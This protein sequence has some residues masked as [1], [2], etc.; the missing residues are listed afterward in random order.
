MSIEV[1]KP[2]LF[3]TIQDLGRVGFQ[4]LGVPVSGVMDELSH[5][6]ANLL[7]GNDEHEATLEITLLGP[8]L[9][10]GRGAWIVLA[11]AD[12]GAVSTAAGP[13]AP[14]AVPVPLETPTWIA[15]GAT[16]Q[17][18]KRRSGL[19][20]YLAVRGGFGVALAMGSR[21]THVRGGIGG[22]EGR[23]LRKGD[24]LP[25]RAAT[26]ASATEAAAAPLSPGVADAL[27]ALR[28]SAPGAPI[29]VTRGREW[30]EFTPA[31]QDAFLSQPAVVGSQSER[32]ASRLQ[33]AVL[34]RRA[35]GDMLSE[36][37]AFGTVQVPPEGQP[38]VLMADRQSTGGYPRIAQVA[39]VDLP[40][41]AQTMPGETVRFDCIELALAQ[42]LLL[43]R[44][45]Q[46][47][48]LRRALGRPSGE[49]ARADQSETGGSA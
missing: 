47:A 46:F 37:V 43:T 15:P 1:M 40:R 22:L 19:R 48:A 10:F 25:L 8:T 16:L 33:G 38:I 44:S 14:D 23:A 7:V 2:G 29:R 42:R 3:S 32:M 24:A 4:H 26:E 20:A 21:S 28:D 12:L 45:Q 13:A 17:F 36:A 35:S 31:A 41:L 34:T 18:G 9:R 30:S 11:G 39:T 6:I 5:R 27:R 49:V